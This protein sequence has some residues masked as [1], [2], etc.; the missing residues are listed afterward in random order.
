MLCRAVTLLRDEAV[1]AGEATQISGIHRTK[2]PLYRK[3]YTSVEYRICQKHNSHYD[4]HETHNESLRKETLTEGGIHSAWN[5][6]I[7]VVP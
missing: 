6:P 7:A 3:D 5:K 2:K 4:G 1:R